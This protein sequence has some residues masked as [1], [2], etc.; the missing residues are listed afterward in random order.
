MVVAHY[1]GCIM[2]VKYYGFKKH[3]FNLTADPEFLFPSP[4]HTEAMSFLYYGIKSR[5]GFLTI[6]GEVGTGKT[7][8]CRA[9]LS[10]LDKNVK[11][12]FIL[13]SNLTEY[14][15]L[16]AIIDD[17][18]IRAARR[19][20][21]NLMRNLNNFLLQQ[22]EQESTATLIID[23]AQNLSLGQL[24][25]VRMLSNLETA[26][27]KL[28]QIVLVGQP[29][30][31]KKLDSKGLLQL[32]QRIAIRFHLYPLKKSEV[33][34][35][36]G[37]RLGVAGGDAELVFDEKAVDLVYEYSCGVPRIINLVCDKALL[38]GFVLGTKTITGR[39]AKASIREIE[40]QPELT[41]AVAR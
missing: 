13:N 1:A 14:Q 2:Y 18:G 4:Q 3:P 29:Q 6:T 17:F 10:R 12:A 19:N 38:A 37:H 40:G 5:K 15:L 22:A 31:R 21:M 7:T 27:C 41:A 26:E 28:L 34:S 36:I 25:Q 39:I 24:E 9:L 16:K 8:L 11:T 32:R 20:R 30:L 23:E 35:Y 33:A